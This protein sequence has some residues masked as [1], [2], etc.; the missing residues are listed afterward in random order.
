[1][2]LALKPAI[3]KGQTK[4]RET[5]NVYAVI[6]GIDYEGE[7]L[8]T[9]QLFD[10]KSAAQAYRDKLIGQCGVDYVKMEVF[11]VQMQSAIAA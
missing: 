2:T 9:M 6:A 3:L 7:N 10:C 4:E 11:P 5:M 1:L 8:D